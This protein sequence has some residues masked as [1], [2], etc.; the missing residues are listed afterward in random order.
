MRSVM[1][2]RTSKESVIWDSNID[3]GQFAC[4]GRTGCKDIA[5]EP[6][7]TEECQVAYLRR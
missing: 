5:V 6:E 1:R 2:L 3:I 7:V 4:L